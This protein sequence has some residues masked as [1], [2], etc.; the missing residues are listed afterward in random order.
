MLHRPHS[1]GE[2]QQREAHR[3]GPPGRAARGGRRGGRAG[4]PGPRHGRAARAGVLR[5]GRQ[6]AYLAAR[7]VEHPVP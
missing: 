3:G 5:P 1:E 6:E 2:R 7:L 4:P